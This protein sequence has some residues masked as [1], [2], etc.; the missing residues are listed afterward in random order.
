VLLAKEKISKVQMEE[1]KFGQKKRKEKNSKRKEI[2]K[3]EHRKHSIALLFVVP[4]ALTIFLLLP[5]ILVS[6][7]TFFTPLFITIGDRNTYR[8][9]TRTSAPDIYSILL[10]ITDLCATYT[11]LFFYMPPKLHIYFR[12]VQKKTLAISGYA[13]QVSFALIVRTL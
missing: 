7:Y 8:I 2:E 1:K 6:I 13:F 11:Y 3:G 4:F 5:F 9:A 12:L 10:S